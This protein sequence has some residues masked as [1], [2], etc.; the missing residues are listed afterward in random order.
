MN[1]V[2]LTPVNAEPLTVLQLHA[3]LTQL[4]QEGEGERQVQTMYHSR[5][6]PS[7]TVCCV[8]KGDS[9]G[10][11]TDWGTVEGQPCLWLSSK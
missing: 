5:R 6:A 8:T 9:D 1:E 7:Y 2:C 10:E 4:I 3:L 11:E